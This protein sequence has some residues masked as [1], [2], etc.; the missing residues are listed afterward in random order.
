MRPASILVVDDHEDTRDF[1]EFLLRTEGYELTMAADGEQATALYRRRP[2]DVVLLDI[3]LPHKDGIQTILELRREFPDVAIIAM[4]ADGSFGR[5]NALARA[6][7]AGALYTIR[8]PLEP[9][10]L[11]RAIEGLVMGRR[12]K[13]P[14]P[15][16]KAVS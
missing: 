8:K 15:R 9:W 6:R 16:L 11:L 3:F 13:R 4:S 5:Q 7:E 14:V 12:A 10:V 2:T 1:L